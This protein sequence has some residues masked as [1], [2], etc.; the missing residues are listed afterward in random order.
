MRVEARDGDKPWKPG[1]VT[2][3]R[4]LRV[5]LDTELSGCGWDDVRPY[6][7]AKGCTQIK[8]VVGDLQKKI[9]EDAQ[10]M[11][12]EAALAD[13]KF[14]VEAVRA[15][16]TKED[17]SPEALRDAKLRVA[18][19]IK[20]AQ[21]KG[22][23]QKE[24]VE[25]SSAMGKAQEK[26]KEAEEAK[27]NK[28][29]KKKPAKPAPP[30]IEFDNAA[31]GEAAKEAAEKAK[32]EDKPLPEIIK[33]AEDAAKAVEGASIEDIKKARKKGAA[34]AME[35]SSSS[36]DSSDSS[37]TEYETELAA[38]EK[39]KAM[40]EGIAAAFYFNAHANGP[41]SA[42]AQA[43]PAAAAADAGAMTKAAPPPPP[44]PPA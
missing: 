41:S 16:A 12:K 13:L 4:P 17:P 36:S 14:A 20:A 7:E 9:L 27:K 18:E 39:K 42:P 28:G 26:E 6:D 35:G 8:G 43:A 37:D 22:V 10:A 21:S 34:V 25:A 3:V 11:V 5:K 23:S 44:P 32:E 19:A 31:V 40:R 2:C 15:L 33:A 30:V 24:L 1:V 38:A 29:K